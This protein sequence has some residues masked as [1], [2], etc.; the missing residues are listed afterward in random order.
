[1]TFK[2]YL[3]VDSC[4][5]S[6]K[7]KEMKNNNELSSPIN[8]AVAHKT[9]DQGGYNIHYYVSGEEHDEVIVF[10]HPA[11]SDHRAFDP[12]IDFFSKNYKVIT[13]DLIGHGL[14][15]AKKSKDKID[16][17]PVHIQSI[18]VQEHADQVHL[19]GVSMGSLVAQ[20]FAY[21]YPERIKSLTALGGYNIHT[22]N[23]EVTRA[24]GLSNLGLIVRALFSM[25]SF[26]NKVAQI[27]CKSEKGQALFYETVCH[28]ERKSFLVMQG[29][30]HII[31]TRNDFKPMYPTLVLTGE[32]D[33]DLARKMAKEWYTHLNSKEED[34][35]KDAGHCA[36]L[37]Q[38]QA[39]N[40]RVHAFIQGHK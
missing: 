31:K 1:M 12:Q 5:Y 18:I 40:E 37:D 28:Y 20:Y 38:P 3:E 21:R 19:V 33:I 24:Q 25:S 10:L 35:L 11:F 4:R 2:M 7:V 23:K 26:R 6:S 8:S 27:T 22:E 29:F 39:F 17:S 15:K 30:R 14:S 9:L 13:I 16:A 34:L 32:H 36:N